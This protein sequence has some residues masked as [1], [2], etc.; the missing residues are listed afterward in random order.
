MLKPCKGCQHLKEL[1]EFT[2]NKSRPDGLNFYCKECNKKRRKDTAEERNH[3]LRQW[4]L[5]NS[6]KAKEGTYNSRLKRE[7]NLT[8]ETY[9]KMLEKQRGVCYICG[10]PPN[11]RRLAVDHCHTTGAV[12]GLLCVNCNRGVGIFKNSS[13][14]LRAAAEYLESFQATA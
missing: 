6:T 8:L 14:L 13:Q 12:R 5:N 10:L 11:G 7:Y 3:Y 1:S 2:K 4:R 9:N